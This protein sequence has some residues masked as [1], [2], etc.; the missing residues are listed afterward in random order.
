MTPFETRHFAPAPKGF[1]LFSKEINVPARSAVEQI[2]PNVIH[3]T[4]LPHGGHFAAMEQ[5]EVLV[6]DIRTFFALIRSENK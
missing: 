5:P 6:K 4:E 1:V 3:W 2:V